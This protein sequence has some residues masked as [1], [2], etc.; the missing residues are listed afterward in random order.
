MVISGSVDSEAYG[1]DRDGIDAVDQKAGRHRRAAAKRA[2]Q[3]GDQVDSFVA[4]LW[5]SA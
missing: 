4:A 5:S 1:G 2:R 3:H